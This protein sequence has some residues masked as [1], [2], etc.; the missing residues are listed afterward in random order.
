[1]II[2]MEK[3]GRILENCNADLKNE[4]VYDTGDHPCIVNFL[5]FHETKLIS[6]KFRNLGPIRC[7]GEYIE[8]LVCLP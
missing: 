7:L 5:E 4:D 8:G 6:S 2:C 1:M 3:S